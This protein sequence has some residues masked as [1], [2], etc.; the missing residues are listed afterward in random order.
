MGG[1]TTH[2][3][4]VVTRILS[5]RTVSKKNTKKKNRILS[6]SSRVNG[7]VH[8]TAAAV[9]SVDHGHAGVVGAVR[10][11]ASLRRPAPV[12]GEAGP[13]VGHHVEP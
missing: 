1:G 10:S 6:E 8:L 13:A 11:G 3:L 2:C 4:K 5:E 9:T 12:V 7:V